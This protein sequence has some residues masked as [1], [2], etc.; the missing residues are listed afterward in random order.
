MAELGVLGFDTKNLSDEFKRC[1]EIVSLGYGLNE[2]PDEL[3]QEDEQ[4]RMKLKHVTRS[5]ALATLG[6]AAGSVSL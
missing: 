5:Y 1:D 6:G 3:R 2:I 4:R